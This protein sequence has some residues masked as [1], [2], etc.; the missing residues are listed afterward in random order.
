MANI[1]PAIVQQLIDG[2]LSSVDPGDLDA[3]QTDIDANMTDENKAAM[4]S[5]MLAQQTYINKQL[6][7]TEYADIVTPIEP[8]KQ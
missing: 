5:D 1:H 3:A 2:Y 4:V 8:I 6:A 7:K